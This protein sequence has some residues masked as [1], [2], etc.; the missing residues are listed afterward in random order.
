MV[1]RHR[2]GQTV[3][4]GG[5]FSSRAGKADRADDM[6]TKAGYLKSERTQEHQD[7][8]SK[9]YQQ[10]LDIS[11][12]QPLYSSSGAVGIINSPCLPCKTGLQGQSNEIS[13]FPGC[14]EVRAK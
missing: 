9:A 12:L 10:D 6:S 11:H 13:Q 14:G 5:Q 1:I 3:K 2:T 4:V 7:S 8:S